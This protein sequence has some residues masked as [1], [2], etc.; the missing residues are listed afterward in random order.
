MAVNSLITSEQT[1]FPTKESC[2]KVCDVEPRCK[3][4]FYGKAEQLCEL[5]PESQKGCTAFLGTLHFDNCNIS[6]F[7]VIKYI[8]DFQG[9]DYFR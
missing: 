3:Y 1:T 2:K 4:Y 6:K 9:A 7:N 5:Y 8:L